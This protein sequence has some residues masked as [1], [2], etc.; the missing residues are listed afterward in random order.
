MKKVKT[1]GRKTFQ[2]I[3]IKVST[4]SSDSDSDESI[5]ENRPIRQDDSTLLPL[6][7]FLSPQPKLFQKN[8][9]NKTTMEDDLLKIPQ[10]TTHFMQEYKQQ[11]VQVTRVCFWLRLVV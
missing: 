9:V 7:S 4:V 10:N 11:T 5:K 3:P 1:Y 8:P 6:P 2:Y